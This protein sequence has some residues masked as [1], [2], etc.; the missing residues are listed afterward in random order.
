MPSPHQSLQVNVFSVAQDNHVKPKL[1]A[2]DTKVELLENQVTDKVKSRE[3][4]ESLNQLVQDSTKKTNAQGKL[5]NE[6]YDV[7]LERIGTLCKTI[8]ALES[9]RASS[10]SGYIPAVVDEAL[11]DDIHKVSSE[12]HRDAYLVKSGSKRSW[13][14]QSHTGSLK[15]GPRKKPR[16]RP[17]AKDN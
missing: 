7:A 3:G 2:L 10:Q 6:I 17:R 13:E 4:I 16:G 15:R 8:I 9:S 14:S 5:N 12:N 11:Q 1:E